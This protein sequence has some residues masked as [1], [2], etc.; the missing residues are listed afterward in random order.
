MSAR[1][2]KVTIEVFPHGRTQTLKVR[3][4]GK[5]AHLLLGKVRKVAYRQTLTTADTEQLYV[6]QVLTLADALVLS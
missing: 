2:L 1:A 3:A 4:S 5:F 6:H